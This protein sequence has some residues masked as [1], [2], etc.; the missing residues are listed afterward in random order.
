[1]LTVAEQLTW[2]AHIMSPSMIDKYLAP[3]Q[4]LISKKIEE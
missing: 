3:T 1:M 4:N 2:P